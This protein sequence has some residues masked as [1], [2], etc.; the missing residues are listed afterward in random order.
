[1]TTAPDA[2]AE[3][4]PPPTSRVLVDA[5]S[6]PRDRGGV[7]RY[8]DELLPALVAEG[9]DVVVVHQDH[10][11]QHYAD[12]V[13]SVRRL[14]A[15][16]W[17][18][19]R[20]ARLVWEQVA[21]PRMARS[22]GADVVHCPHYTM[23]LLARVPVV[24]TLHDATFWSH[25]EAH[26]RVKRVFF[27]AWSRVSLRRAARCITPSAATKDELVRV[28]G[29]D[30]SRIDVAHLGV[31]SSV[32]HP[33]TADRVDALRVELAIPGRYLAFLGT[34][35]PRKNVPALIDAWVSACQDTP[36]PPSLV[37][38]GGRG[39]DDRLEGAVARVPSSLRLLRPGYLPL[40]R[41]S[42][43]LNGAEIVVY[44]SVGEGF[45]LPVLEAMSAGAA[46][47]TTRRL[48][49]PEVGGDAVQYA[50]PDVGSLAAAITDLLGSPSRT[51][52]L[53][54]AGARRAATFTWAACARVH[55]ATYAMAGRA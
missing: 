23:P 38:V 1:M 30:R 11:A 16:S 28:A 21:L 29:G 48:A 4:A 18:R 42:P 55:R 52:E 3:T 26:L 41:L 22:V 2:R 36:D 35:E 5:T 47:L 49:I 45:G 19:R 43:L 15:P 50:E 32:F 25:P 31:D 14:A 24:V 13:P 54:S 20:P 6:V 27:R 51:E 40:D 39:W 34:L 12:L 10:D 7:G 9:Q 46:V 44:P 33:V 17:A 53:R 37:L 8:V